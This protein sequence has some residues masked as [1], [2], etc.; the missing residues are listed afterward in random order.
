MKN[1]AIF[2]G[3]GGLGAFFVKRLVNRAQLR[4]GYWRGRERAE[5]LAAGQRAL[6][7]DVQA[8]QVDVR[9]PDSVSDFLAAAAAGQGL[10][11]VIG[12]SGPVMPLRP[13]ADV[14][15]EDFDRVYATDVRGAFNVIKQGST[16]LADSG[17]GS[18]VWVLTTASLRTLENDG[19][20]AGP[21]T[22]VAAMIK[23]IAREMGP[24]NVRCNGVALAAIDTGMVYAPEFASDEV[25]QGVIN[26]MI[27][28]T[29]LGRMGHPDEVSAV[30]DFLVSPGAGYINGQIIGV[31]GG[32]SA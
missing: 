12:A 32:F 16:L 25:A 17:G 14:S 23:Q 4:I 18:I 8:I 3:S 13:L 10:E 1:I 15:Y 27:R 21:K 19:M 20:S 24:H 7:F 6:G 31:D 5:T 22:A 26:T 11:A 2:G 30:I 9:D 28:N 29:P